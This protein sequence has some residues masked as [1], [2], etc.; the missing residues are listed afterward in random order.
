MIESLYWKEELKRIADTVRR[1][2]APPRWTERRHC[3]VERD[4]MIGFFMLRRLIELSK[5]SADISDRNLTIFSWKSLGISVNKMNC[6]ALDELYD[7]DNEVR[8]SKRP[9]YIANQFIHAYMSFPCRDD[10][11]NWCDMLIVSD[12]DR[13]D[14]IW[15]IP[16]DEIRTLFYD[17]ANDYPSS[18]TFTFDT[19]KNDYVISVGQNEG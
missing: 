11:R 13:N 5:V 12:F 6:G 17:A 1:V 7:M 9:F 15:R 2:D 8:E 3:T 14:C 16:I 10:T 18:A 4:L 19:T